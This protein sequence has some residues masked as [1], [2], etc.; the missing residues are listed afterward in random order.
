MLG[1]LDNDDDDDIV[2]VNVFGIGGGDFHG[3]IEL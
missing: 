1:M 2:G 3:S